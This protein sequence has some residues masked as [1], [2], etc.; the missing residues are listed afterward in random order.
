M[1]VRQEINLLR[2]LPSCFCWLLAAPGWGD[3]VCTQPDRE[4]CTSSDACFTGRASP[5]LQLGSVAVVGRSMPSFDPDPDPDC[6]AAPSSLSPQAPSDIASALQPACAAAPGHRAL[7][8]V[9][10]RIY[11]HKDAVLVH[12]GCEENRHTDDLCMASFCS[13]FG[14]LQ[15]KVVKPVLTGGITILHAAQT[16]PQVGV[17]HPAGPPL[18]ALQMHCFALL[19]LGLL[20]THASLQHG[21]LGRRGCTSGTVQSCASSSGRRSPPQILGSLPPWPA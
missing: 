10:A 16:A 15:T 14:G 1:K 7:H 5:K 17:L 18:A 21:R 2:G 3:G 12:T 13:V 8:E 9:L 6:T 20:H 4:Q 11:H 19:P